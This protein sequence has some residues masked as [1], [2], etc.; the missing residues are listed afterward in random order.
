MRISVPIN[1]RLLRVLWVIQA[2]ATVAEPTTSEPSTAAIAASI[3][4]P[5]LA[6]WLEPTEEPVSAGPPPIK[7][8][9]ARCARYAF[10]LPMTLLFM[11]SLSGNKHATSYIAKITIPMIKKFATEI[12]L[13]L[14]FF[15]VSAAAHEK[16][17]L[18][19]AMYVFCHF[20]E[21]SGIWVA[22]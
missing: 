21:F 1:S 12:L 8:E 16:I 5:P 13:V 3:A 15:S 22:Q 11:M 2:V 20:L 14:T 6:I 10:P 17:I 7:R 18:T 9:T 4:Y 19:T